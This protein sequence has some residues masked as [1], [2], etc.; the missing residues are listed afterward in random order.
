MSEKIDIDYD[1]LAKAMKR[2]GIFEQEPQLNMATK[3]GI[4]LGGFGASSC[5]LASNVPILGHGIKAIGDIRRGM[6]MGYAVKM[7]MIKQEEERRARIAEMAAQSL[8]PA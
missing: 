5:Y 8:A 6:S 4:A 7:Q 2:Q 3:L 1:E